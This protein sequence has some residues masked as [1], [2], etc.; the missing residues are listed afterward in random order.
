MMNKAKKLIEMWEQEAANLEANK[1]SNSATHAERALTDRQVR[2]LRK[3]IY[4]AELLLLNHEPEASTETLPFSKHGDRR[5]ATPSVDTLNIK[6]VGGEGSV[7][8]GADRQNEQAKEVLSGF[9]IKIV[10]SP[11]VERGTGV[12]MVNAADMPDLTG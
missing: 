7:Q 5:S 12:L 10:S 3:C 9:N 11:V 4:E 2:Q 6:E 1:Y 8:P